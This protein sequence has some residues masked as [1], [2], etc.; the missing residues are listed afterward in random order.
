MMTLFLRF[1][2]L[3]FSLHVSSAFLVSSSSVTRPSTLVVALS[4]DDSTDDDDDNTITIGL[5]STEEENTEFMDILSSHKSLK[6]LGINLDSIVMTPDDFGDQVDLVD[7]A[8]FSSEK[9]VDDWLEQ[10][11]C[12]IDGVIDADE[13]TN[14]NVVAVCLS[15]DVAGACLQGGRWESRNIY[16]P[17][18]ENTEVKLWVD[19]CVQALGDVMERKFWGG[20]W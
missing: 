18:G 14:G 15:K 3:L 6:M 8:C 1:L 20:G 12:V 4:D 5:T 17:K 10:I 13:K 16:Y 2:L 11:D 9:A 7:I 19:S